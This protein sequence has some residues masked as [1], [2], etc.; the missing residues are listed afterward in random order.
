LV[1]P[2]FLNRRIRD[3]VLATADTQYAEG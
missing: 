2:K 1:T 3:R